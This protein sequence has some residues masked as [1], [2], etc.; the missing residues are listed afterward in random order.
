MPRASKP[1]VAQ[2]FAEELPR[3]SAAFK[4]LVWKGIPYVS[5]GWI[6][7]RKLDRETRYIKRKRGES[8]LYSE[9]HH[10]YTVSRFPSAR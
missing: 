7:R 5:N 8:W 4:R 1:T 9:Q 2:I 10:T 6:V 3:D